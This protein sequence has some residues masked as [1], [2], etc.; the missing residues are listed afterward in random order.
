MVGHLTVHW[1]LRLSYVDTRHK[2]KK[3][4]EKDTY[5]CVKKLQ[6]KIFLP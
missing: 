4:Q 1:S 2:V 3:D 5:I 6:Y